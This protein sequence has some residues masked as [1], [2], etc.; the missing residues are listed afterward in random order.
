MTMSCKNLSNHDKKE[1]NNRNKN[2]KQNQKDLSPNAQHEG[3][4]EVH[5][6][7][8]W[9]AALKV[10]YTSFSLDCSKW[11]SQQFLASDK[12]D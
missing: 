11:G 5:C 6:G 2:S 3:K 8:E 4:G 9:E 10:C 7:N 1:N 12:G